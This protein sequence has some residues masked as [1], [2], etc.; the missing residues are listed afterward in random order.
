MARIITMLALFLALT[1]VRSYAIPHF[2]INPQCITP[3][4]GDTITVFVEVDNFTNIASF[5]YSMNWN[6]AVMQFISVDLT[7]T[8]NLVDLSGGNFGT[9]QTSMGNLNV[10]WNN[11][12]AVGTTLPNDSKIYRLRYKI[13]T[14][15]TP[16]VSFSGNPTS[17]EVVNGSGNNESPTF[18]GLNPPGQ[19]GTSAGFAIIA[20]DTTGNTGDTICVSIT[21]QDFDEIVS[22][23]YSMHWNPAVL[24]YVGVMNYGL[25]DFSIA[26][27]NENNSSTLS[28]V[29][30]DNATTGVTRPDGYILYRVCF[31]VIGAAGTSST[32]T[33]DGTPTV[34]EIANT[35]GVIPFQ[36]DAGSVTVNSGG[37]NTDCP[38]NVFAIIF[39]DT[40]YTPGSVICVPVRV[41]NFNSIASMQF[42][43]H[44]NASHF[45]LTNVTGFN[46]PDLSTANFNLLD[47]VNGNL[48]FLWFDNLTTG[49]T[50]PNGTSIFT[51]CFRAEGAVGS[52]S[53]VFVNG[54][55]T[56]IEVVNGSGNPV[57]PCFQP[58]TFS[59]SANCN[60]GSCSLTAA[61]VTTHVTCNGGTD[62]A[63]DLSVSGSATPTYS[64][65]GPGGFTATTQDITGRPA[66]TYMVTV[67]AAGC[68]STT[69][70]F[71][72]TEPS[73]I[74]I[75]SVIN[76]VNCFGSS[77]GDIN[78]TVNGGPA[79]TNYTYLW[80]TNPVVTTQDLTNVSAGLY[81]VTVTSTTG[82]CT[83]VAANLL[84]TQPGLP[85]TIGNANITP[86]SCNTV[87]NGAI[88]INP[89]GGTGAYQYNWTGLPGN[90]DPQDRSNL[91]TGTYT[92][93]VQDENGCTATGSYTVGLAVPASLSFTQTNITCNGLCNGSIDLTVNGATGTPSYSWSGAGTVPG[94][95]DQFSLCAGAY[96]VTVT[97]GNG[98]TGV[99]AGITITQPQP[100]NVQGVTNP[101]TT[102][103]NGSI[104]LTVTGG[105]PGYT[106][107]WQIAPGIVQGQQDQ[108]GLSSGT[109][110]VTVSD[111]NGCT[112][113]QSYM[114][115]GN[116]IIVGDT[117]NVIPSGCPGEANGGIYIDVY[118]GVGQLQYQ[119]FNIANPGNIINANQ[120]I[121]GLLPGCYYVIITD[122]LGQT[123]S[124]QSEPI[125]VTG[126]SSNL[127]INF[128]ADPQTGPVSS[129]LN[130]NIFINVSGGTQPYV[131]SWSDLPGTPDPEDRL[132]IGPGLYC[133]TVGDTTGC[134]EELCVTVPYIPTALV[135]PASQVEV[136]DVT[137]FGDTDGSAILHIQGGDAPYSI[138][139]GGD[140]IE[141]NFQQTVLINGLGAGSYLF[142]VQDSNEQSVDVLVV[143]DEP[144]ALS[145]PFVATNAQCICNGS[146]VLSPTGGTPSGG[147]YF[148]NWND[149]A[150]SKD[151]AGL[152]PGSSYSC[153]I[154]DA[155]GCSVSIGPVS[156]VDNSTPLI[157]ADV[158]LVNVVCE[159]DDD[160]SIAVSLS[161]GV[162]P[163]T[164]IWMDDN[165]NPIGSGNEIT[166][167]SPG[168]YSV[169]IADGCPG[170]DIIQQFEISATTT[171]NLSNILVTPTSG[172]G[173]QDGAA[174][175]VVT[176]GNPN[177][178]Y[179][180]CGGTNGPNGTVSGLPAGPCTVTVTD[181]DGCVV[182]GEFFVPSGTGPIPDMVVNQHVSCYDACDGSAT[183]N[184]TGGVGPFS[185]DWEGGSTQK[186]A[187]NLCA[188]VA[189]VTV[190]DG[191]GNEY[192]FNVEITQ[193]DPIFVNV[194]VTDASGANF[195]DGS[196]IAEVEGGT[197]P[198]TYLWNDKNQ[199]T[200]PEVDSLTPGSNYALLIEDA[201]GCSELIQNI[202]VGPNIL[203]S[204]FESSAVLTPNEDGK[205]DVFVVSCNN[206]YV[207]HLEIY[208]RW[209]QLV[210]TSNDY[211]DDWMGR[212]EDGD[213][214]PEGGYYY[215]IE[216]DSGNGIKQY[217]GAISLIR[218][219]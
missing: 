101:P 77:T 123:I 144:A 165:G 118:G 28:M 88:D 62:G 9:T 107:S 54:I 10:S 210:F 188:G 219:Q 80:S 138:Y 104:D 29:W 197:A 172:V 154:T 97:D 160:G 117:I 57:T 63:V 206:I 185:Y 132:D 157:L 187:N 192:V 212:D 79:G 151:R 142:E 33:F 27:F 92:V 150:T 11:A 102:G 203:L 34:I 190:T 47:T 111:I 41:Q 49:I 162:A 159:S 31:R 186:T 200:T 155:N 119:W 37:G 2:S 191:N 134:F 44:W 53:D 84:I 15:A 94:S 99:L 152:C 135:V 59:I 46:L 140:L 45:A 173:I 122:A 48:P 61:G 136:N 3:A 214:L 114:L 86:A 98:C 202:N 24:D 12:Q 6:P 207:I 176:G 164:I 121:Q 180:W 171:L 39:P 82:S 58:G 32:I 73:A 25:P 65:T 216:A 184:L 213:P 113:A 145:V 30:F 143:I 204:C 76:D 64:W 177:Y 105:T 133:V 42:S 106:Y 5:Q 129:G 38:S 14:S 72:I 183:I 50:V 189:D 108:S 21:A 139:L 1:A 141:T 181:E 78:I 137:C 56:P 112:N 182:Q 23:Q 68:T 87:C 194:I 217:K 100:L 81:S 215:I 20:D 163:Y 208:N 156:I 170:G 17:I 70:S 95:Q 149:G 83:A 40:C 51:L 124:T 120:D 169:S 166:G 209:G 89:T 146:I 8:V 85:L 110:F 196:A 91:C 175:A 158:D 199:S 201:N 90:D 128:I 52:S 55:P 131:F 153:T 109:Y 60:T 116:T 66:G 125:C 75:T 71:T 195:S 168:N 22:M 43:M 103:N 179:T 148:Y 96:S 36:S 7:G 174:Q 93:T 69:A 19:C 198:Y 218:E 193:P 167:L 4:V 130:G 74:T 115:Q 67:T 126:S 205:N 127:N 178:S 13:L 161:G 16:V 18:A 211:Q 147:V 35:S 26:N